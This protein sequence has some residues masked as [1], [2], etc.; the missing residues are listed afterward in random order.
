MLP[1]ISLTRRALL[2]LGGAF[3]AR[4]LVAPRT[5]ATG[6]ATSDA[7]T[8]GVLVPPAPAD[9][10]AA[11]TLAH[12]LAGIRMG[13]EE[14]SQTAALLGRTVVLRERT[15][16]SAEDARALVGQGAAA[17][18]TGLVPGS[19]AMLAATVPGVPVIDVLEEDDAPGASCGP[20]WLFHVAPGRARRAAVAADSSGTAE[21]P[22]VAWDPSLE[23]YGAAQLND[24]F[25]A[26][27][28]G[29]MDEPADITFSAERAKFARASPSGIA[30]TALAISSSRLSFCASSNS[31]H[32]G[33]RTSPLCVG[34]AGAPGSGNGAIG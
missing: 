30:S 14:A 31:S 12:V 23:K 19:S 33:N 13:A 26:R 9:T 21:A 32:A 8:V 28:A 18:L 25:R 11:A 27:G 29:E 5:T 7:I 2:A 10:A 20:A 6:S 17:L 1:D 24:R 34:S 22:V 15:G 4:R 3:V 16:T